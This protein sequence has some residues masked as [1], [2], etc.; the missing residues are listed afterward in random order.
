MTGALLSIRPEFSRAILGGTKTVELRRR[1]PACEPGDRL[2]VYETSPT[3]AIVGIATVHAVVTQSPSAL[4]SRV[5]NY[6]AVSRHDFRSYFAGQRLATGIKIA[7][8]A[9]FVKPMSLVEA[10]RIAPM[11]N[12]PRSWCYLGSLPA[13]LLDK[14]IAMA[15]QCN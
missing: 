10:R 14:L 4:W 7:K 5:R 6:A 2:V 13:E 8:P 12:P 15:D 11:F 3:M 1:A 9:V